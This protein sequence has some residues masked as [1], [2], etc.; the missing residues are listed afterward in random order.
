MYND[1]DI[2]VCKIEIQLF[3]LKIP[4]SFSLDRQFQSNLY[5]LVVLGT[6]GANV[7]IVINIS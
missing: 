4:Y 1:C 2:K 6:C 3:Y 5:A 7:L